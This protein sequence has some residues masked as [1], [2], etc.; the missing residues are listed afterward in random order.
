[1][2]DDAERWLVP[3]FVPKGIDLCAVFVAESPHKEELK[4]DKKD[5]H[6]PFRGSPGRQWWLEI[7]GCATP[8]FQH[9]AQMSTR[10]ELEHVC[11]KL[12]IQS[13]RKL[14]TTIPLVCRETI[15]SST[16]ARATVK[17][18]AMAKGRSD[19]RP[20]LRNIAV[21]DR[22][23]RVS[24]TW[25]NAWNVSPRCLHNSSAWVTT[26]NGLSGRRF[27]SRLRSVRSRSSRL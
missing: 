5:E 7:F 12:R 9:P 27:S 16:R 17:V 3:D 8:H 14:P 25:R 18:M 26:P 20:F 11:R 19:I 6:S 15:Y 24:W 10:A 4:P 2:R 23:A 13:T 21:L 22:S 1:M